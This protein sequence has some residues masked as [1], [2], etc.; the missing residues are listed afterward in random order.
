MWDEGNYPQS[1]SWGDSYRDSWQEY[2]NHEHYGPA[3]SSWRIRSHATAMH[4]PVHHPYQPPQHQ[5]PGYNRHL[6]NHHQAPFFDG[7][8]LHSN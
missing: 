4:A 1:D 7:P 6:A 3:T 5:H 8:A 2:Q